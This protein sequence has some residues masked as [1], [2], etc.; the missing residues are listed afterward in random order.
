M[1]S[2]DGTRQTPIEA[3]LIKDG[4]ILPLKDVEVIVGDE[5]IVF[6]IK[7]PARNLSGMYQIK[8]SNG[9]G[10]VIQDCNITM[11]GI[12]ERRLMQLQII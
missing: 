1:L 6:K 7:K 11:Q 5:K 8:L 2:V 10:E 3:K 9:Q 12:I 4:K